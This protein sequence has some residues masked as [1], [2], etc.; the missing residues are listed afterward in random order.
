MVS[1]L[2][3]FI[4]TIIICTITGLVILSSGVWTEKFENKFEESAMCYLD[5]NYSDQSQQDIAILQDYILSCSGPETFTGREEI[6]DGVMQNNS[7]TL[8]HNRSVAEQI[9]YKQDGQ[10]FNGFIVVDNGK[11]NTENLNV[12]GNSLLIGAD[13]T[14]K[15]F[16]RSIFGEYGQYIVAIGLL[17]FAF[18][19]AIAWSYYGDRATV[20][21]FGEGW[22]LYYRIIYVGAFFTAAIIDTKIVW[23]IAT[24]IGPIATV[25][26]LLAILFLRKEIKKLDAEYV[27]VKN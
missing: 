27:V 18:S 15:A 10:L 9:L 6:V 20:H 19:T 3:P 13:L 4:D 25:P 26:N 17:L 16:T 7:I 14:G 21:L 2:E 23:D 11:L 22:V 1:I 5:G 12:E 24:V 8:M